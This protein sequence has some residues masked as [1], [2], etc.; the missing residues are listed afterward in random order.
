MALNQIF[1]KFVVG[2]RMEFLKGIFQTRVLSTIEDQKVK[3]D[4]RILVLSSKFW[5]RGTFI[6]SQYSKDF[7]CSNA[8]PFELL[9][10]VVQQVI[11]FLFIF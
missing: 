3:M 5:G 4:V 2:G 10:V 9:P 1:Q 11:Q 6:L 8:T 7:F